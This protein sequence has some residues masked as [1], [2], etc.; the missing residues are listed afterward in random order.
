MTNPFLAG[1]TLPDGKNLKLEPWQLALIEPHLVEQP[2]QQVKRPTPADDLQTYTWLRHAAH[3]H[4]ALE[5]GMPGEANRFAEWYV[6]PLPDW[7]ESRPVDLSTAF[8]KWR[9]EQ[10][11]KKAAKNRTEET[12]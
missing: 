12:P 10:E 8:K 4:A 2:A 1:L 7:C 6:E 3:R 9:K 11:A 5:E